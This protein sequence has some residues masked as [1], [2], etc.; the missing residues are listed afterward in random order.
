VTFP[1]GALKGSMLSG[2]GVPDARGYL[3]GYSYFTS[4]DAKPSSKAT[5]RV[6]KVNVSSDVMVSEIV[7]PRVMKGGQAVESKAGMS[8]DLKRSVL[9]VDGV[10]YPSK[11]AD[12][13]AG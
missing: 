11:R 9:S 3:S 13:A 4:S 5:N 10:D 6:V 12:G 1:P 2:L 7:G 8:A